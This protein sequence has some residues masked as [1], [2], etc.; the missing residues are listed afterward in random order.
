MSPYNTGTCQTSCV[1]LG[2][3]HGSEGDALGCMQGNPGSGAAPSA[4]PMPSAPAAAASTAA[5]GAAQ[6]P[7]SDRDFWNRALQTPMEQQPGKGA[8]VGLLVAREQPGTIHTL[9]PMCYSLTVLMYDPGGV[10]AAG[11]LAERH[12]CT[13][14]PAGHL[15]R[16][17]QAHST[18]IHG[19]SDGQTQH[20]FAPG[21]ANPL[22]V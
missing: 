1:A 20:R 11:L 13:T 8:Q 5:G 7:A 3:M 4:P 15:S 22:Y 14:D 6:H 2:S 10:A 21:G 18:C 9:K 19:P 17:L 12:I 16:R